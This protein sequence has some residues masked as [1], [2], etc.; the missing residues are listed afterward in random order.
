MIGWWVM[1]MLMYI[2]KYMAYN[3]YQTLLMLVFLNGNE[4][5]TMNI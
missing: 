5:N 4:I 3:F 1:M 2:S